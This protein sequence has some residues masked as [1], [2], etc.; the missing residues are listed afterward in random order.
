MAG[1]E[2]LA[3][4]GSVVGTGISAI[5]Q[6]Q[7]GRQQEAAAEFQAKQMD[8]QAKD[9]MAVATRDAE[10]EAKK[11]DALLSRQTAVAASSGAGVQNQSVLQLLEDTEAQ[12]AY[13]V[14][15]T[16]YGGQQ[17]A[18]GLRNQA[19]AT[20]AEGKAAKTGAYLGAAGTL[21]SGFGSAYKQKY[22]GY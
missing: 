20:R 7:A 11:K 18:A 3:A 16:I 15:S 8:Q 10:Q 13:N 14:A 19:A 17:E 2:T 21:A 12:G 22:G 5:G 9:K 4:I 1:L 6:I